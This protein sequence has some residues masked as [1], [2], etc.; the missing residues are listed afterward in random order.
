MRHRRGID[1]GRPSPVARPVRPVT[2]TTLL[3]HQRS[4]E[5]IIVHC[6]I[7]ISCTHSAELTWDR[8]IACFGPAFNPIANRP[9][10]IRAL[11]CSRCGRRGASII[12]TPPDWV[13]SSGGRASR[14]P[15]G[16]G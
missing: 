4:G 12:L 15:G 2:L 9:R 7:D 6:N 16:A 11:R 8:L 13:L 5:R 3:D 14:R 10:L 1:L